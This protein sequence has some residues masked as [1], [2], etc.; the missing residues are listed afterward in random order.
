MTDSLINYSLINLQ[1]IRMARKK[2]INE[3][4]G[5]KITQIVELFA[6]TNKTNRNP[7]FPAD[8]GDNAALGGTVEFRQ[9]QTG[10]PHGLFSGVRHAGQPARECRRYVLERGMS[11]GGADGFVQ[12]K[13]I[14]RT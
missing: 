14:G 12:Q 5:V 9:G 10:N 6:D 2:G 4:P 8:I 1:L 13:N 3:F 11:W 7:A